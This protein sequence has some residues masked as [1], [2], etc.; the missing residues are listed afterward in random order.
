VRRSAG[1]E[2]IVFWVGAIIAAAGKKV[3]QLL[4][5]SASSTISTTFDMPLGDRQE[6]LD[7][8][9]QQMGLVKQAAG[10][11]HATLGM[12]QRLYGR[13]LVSGVG[14]EFRDR[15]ARSGKTRLGLLE[16]KRIQH[17]RAAM[18]TSRAYGVPGSPTVSLV[19]ATVALTSQLHKREA[20]A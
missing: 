2:S 9:E 14:G 7:F 12:C 17:E 18:A 10:L 16:A 6:V 3:A 5:P 1:I 20:L 15:D 8:D 19:F 11:V 13:R 4:A